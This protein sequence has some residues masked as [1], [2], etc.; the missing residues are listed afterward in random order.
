MLILT[1]QKIFV[2]GDFDSGVGSC[3]HHC[4]PSC[5]PAQVG[6]EWVYGCRHKAWPQNRAGD[7][8]PIV[9]CGGDVGK[10]DMKGQSFV[11]HY[12]RGQSVR[13]INAR[14]KAAQ[15]EKALAEIEALTG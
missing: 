9:E 10:C 5:H 15:A 11:S 14:K 4:S 8:V 3:Q 6:P 1:G 7:F 13:A 12:K 2:D